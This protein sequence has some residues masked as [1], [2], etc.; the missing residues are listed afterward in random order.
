LLVMEHNI[1]IL[2]IRYASRLRLIQDLALAGCAASCLAGEGNQL[3]SL[4]PSD[5]PRFELI[6]PVWPAEVDKPPVWL[7]KDDALSPPS[8]GRTCGTNITSSSA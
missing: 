4:P 2:R 5:S 1:M 3:G 7:W 8:S 6:E